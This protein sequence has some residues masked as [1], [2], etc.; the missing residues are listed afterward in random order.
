[1][2]ESLIKAENRNSKIEIGTPGLKPHGDCDFSARLKSCPDEE[3]LSSVGN[4]LV[5]I[6]TMRRG[7][8][9]CR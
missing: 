6:D 3:N 1:M 9:D 7:G 5:Q 8:I 2:E 4:D